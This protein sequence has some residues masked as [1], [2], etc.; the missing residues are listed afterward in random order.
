MELEDDLLMFTASEKAT[1]TNAAYPSS[2]LSNK[3]RA[4]SPAS[5][6]DKMSQTK[7]DPSTSM[8]LVVKLSRGYVDEIFFNIDALHHSTK[9]CR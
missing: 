9:A 6:G 5:N 3:R 1:Q 2:E 8:K 4:N 7:H